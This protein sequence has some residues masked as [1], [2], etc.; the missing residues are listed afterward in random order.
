MEELEFIKGEMERIHLDYCNNAKDIWANNEGVVA[1][2][3]AKKEYT[4]YRNKYKLLE[5][6]YSK[7]ES[8][9]DELEY[10]K[11]HK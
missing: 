6:A 11:Q 3:L 10:Y 4:K 2:R 9:L 7:I 8:G 5:L 1:E